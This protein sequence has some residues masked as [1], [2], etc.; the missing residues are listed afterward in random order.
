M[1]RLHPT[2]RAG[3]VSIAA[4]V[5]VA[6]AVVAFGTGYTAS[7]AVLGDGGAWLSKGR[8][9]TH[10][11]AA[12][13]QPDATVDH[14]LVPDAGS[15]SVVQTPSSVAVVDPT[16]TTVSTVDTATMAPGATREGK[17]GEPLDYVVLGDRGYVVTGRA[18]Q[19]V[20]ALTL[21]PV[22]PPVEVGQV[23]GVVATSSGSV[24]VLDGRAGTVI[25]LAGGR[26]S[27]PVR[28]APPGPDL[29][30]TAVGGLAVVVD[31]T[32]GTV[33]RVGTGGALDDPI[34]VP[35]IAG[36]TRGD[37]AVNDRQAD[38][39]TAW[40]VVR[41]AGAVV[42][43]DLDTRQVHSGTLREQ[44]AL[45]Q[46]P[47]VVD[48]RVYVPSG[49][50]HTVTVIDA[51]SLEVVAVHE[52]EGT[53]GRL[54]VFARDGRVWIN[55]ATA[56]HALLLSA[57]GRRSSEVDKGTGNGVEEPAAA[58]APEPAPAPAPQPPPEA[59][60][61]PPPPAPAAT[62]TTFAPPPA[63]VPP[64][65]QATV[66][67]VV[68]G[69]RAAACAAIGA[70]RLTCDPRPVGSAPAGTRRDVV[71]AQDP[72][73]GTSVEVNAPVT[74]S[75]FDPDPV[76]VPDVAGERAGP[77]CTD[78]QKAG[79]TCR[80]ATGTAPAG[81]PADTVFAQDPAAGTKLDP[82]DPVTVTS[83]ATIPMPDLTGKATAAACQ[84]AVA[85]DLTC[86]VDSLGTGTP[87]NV[88]QSQDVAPG[89]AVANGGAVRVRAYT[90][91]PVAVPDVR[92]MA[93]DVA[94]AT[95]AGAQL[96]CAWTTTPANSA[97]NPAAVD[98]QSPAPGSAA[99]PGSVVTILHPAGP[100]TT[101]VRY[102]ARSS[103][104]QTLN[105]WAL[106]PDNP[107]AKGYFV[108]TELQRRQDVWPRDTSGS[109][110][111]CYATQ[112]PG[113]V[114]LWDFVR[115]SSDPDHEDHYYAAEGGGN[116]DR[117]VQYYEQS[118]NF[119][120]KRILCYVL[121]EGTSGARR[122]TEWWSGNSHLYATDEVT[123]YSNYTA[124]PQWSFW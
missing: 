105:Q 103:T 43:V 122:V 98:A 108:F 56:R 9:V 100:D 114:A 46:P 115:R 54:E 4:A 45:L 80:P 106:A 24:V 61:P 5:V 47:V 22:G 2:A 13:G 88:V 26:A 44:G 104:G 1:S 75:Y 94:C 92:G 79:L 69:Q 39:A 120:T 55:D 7:R 65:P 36:L 63:S 17:E 116:Y 52:P 28:V 11:N 99:A 40:L 82:G 123:S 124:I 121:P 112:V 6:A 25:E 86:A 76:T 113:A 91:A 89:T 111:T 73:P 83:A 102:R 49:G 81:T 37:V 107:A 32:A 64:P 58:P 20:S 66:P 70:L 84:Q 78:V 19:A 18:V 57:D 53:S 72:A 101:L 41:P 16:T 23:G 119:I 21:D 95:M 10:V 93:Q 3:R 38:G 85:L 15:Q 87:V 59:P 31:S 12:T 74:V 97:N 109:A 68:G 27:L 42:G 90:Q 14:D 35:A 71:L 29:Q 110:G 62:P 50:S 117:G 96:N 60:L 8:T 34:P 30:L 77:A 118:T 67:S 33:R 51:L 48:G